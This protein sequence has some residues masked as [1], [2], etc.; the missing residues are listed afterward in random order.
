MRT[1]A[2]S[3]HAQVYETVTGTIGGDYILI[4]VFQWVPLPLISSPLP[5]N[6]SEGSEWVTLNDGEDS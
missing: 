3:R 1:A 4:S 2:T 5:K 6:F